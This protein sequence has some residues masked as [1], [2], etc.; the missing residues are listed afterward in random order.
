M[1]PSENEGEKALFHISSNA[2][3]LLLKAPL[4]FH[5]L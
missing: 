2:D 5:C 3:P 1:A 4:E